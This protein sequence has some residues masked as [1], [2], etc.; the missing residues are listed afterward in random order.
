MAHSKW[1]ENFFKLFHVETPQDIIGH[2]SVQGFPISLSIA[3]FTFMDTSF[4]VC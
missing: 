2:P 3:A 4:Q 1:F